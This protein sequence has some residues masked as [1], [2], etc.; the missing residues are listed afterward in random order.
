MSSEDNT[1]IDFLVVDDEALIHTLVIRMFRASG[2]KSFQFAYGANEALRIMRSRKVKFLV[3]D[4]IM[5]EMTGIE[6][7]RVVREDPVL[8][9][10]PILVLTGV[11]TAESVV[12]AIE[13]GA[14]GYVVKPFTPV[15]LMKTISS[16]I[17]KKSA[18]TQSQ[19]AEMTKLKLQGSYSK[20]VSLG[21]EILKESRDPNVL[22]MLGECLARDNQ[23]KDAVEVLKESARA[24]K[25]GK[26]NNLLGKIFMEQGDRAQGIQHLKAASEQCHLLQ[27]RKVD[28]AEAYFQSGQENEGEALVQSILKS[29][30]TNLILAD[31]GKLYLEQGDIDR[32]GD[33]LKEDVVPT[34]E[35]VPIFNNYAI[36]LR[37]RSLFEQSEA[38]YRKCIDLVPDSFALY[39]NAGMVSQQM[40]KYDQAESM[41]EH[42]LRLNPSYEPAKVLL[43]SLRSRTSL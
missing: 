10:T 5:P 16:I 30:P 6:L 20:A 32:A 35:T 42:A 37:R 21:R 28:L 22:F 26:S 7:I 27:K 12:C 11:C 24:E 15:K 39:F 29:S 1:P 38:I 18:P 31:L 41:F 9:A 33:L 36:T 2:L 40:K 34:P 4:W 3:T 43:D 14:D 13:E 19:I 8:F 23:L 17:K 25:C